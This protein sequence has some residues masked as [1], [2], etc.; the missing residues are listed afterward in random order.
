VKACKRSIPLLIALV[1]LL[2]ASKSVR[3]ESNPSPLL[4]RTEQQQKTAYQTPTA[5]S[6]PGFSK[7][8]LTNQTTTSDHEATQTPEQSRY[9]WF[10]SVLELL[11]QINWSNW[12]LVAVAIWAGCIAISTLASIR[13]QGK[14]AAQNLIITNRAYLYLSEVRITFDE[15]RNVYDDNTEHPY[16]IVY[17]VYNGGPTPAL[18]IGPFARTTVSAR[19]PTDISESAKALDRPQS[20]VVPP[21]SQQPVNGRYH[22]WVSKE[23][24]DDLRAG[25]R[26]LFFYGLLTYNDIFNNERHPRFTLSFIGTPAEAGKFRPMAFESGKGLNWFD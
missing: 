5:Q 17:P 19:P 24:L 21:R 25:E 3:P 22:Q 11:W 15:P 14:V 1:L 13:E 20:A 16:V 6:S 2:S 8:S 23:E 18:Y 26:K 7:P 4:T 12:A 10:W 9:R